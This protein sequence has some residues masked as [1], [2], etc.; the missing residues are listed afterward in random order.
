MFTHF[1]QLMNR[2]KY[3]FQLLVESTN[4]VTVFSHNLRRVLKR[5]RILHLKAEVAFGNRKCKDMS[6]KTKFS[7]IF[8]LGIGSKLPLL[9]SVL[10]NEKVLQPSKY[11]IIWHCRQISSQ[12][13]YGESAD[14]KIWKMQRPGS[15]LCSYP[16]LNHQAFILK[17]F[18]LNYISVQVKPPLL[19]HLHHLRFNT[20]VYTWFKCCRNQTTFILIMYILNYI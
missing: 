10:N 8:S 18:F 11:C 3:E 1:Q 6:S 17:V 16:D 4:V 12:S 14:A 5:V 7:N 2:R 15:D 13:V 20:F 9:W 19:I